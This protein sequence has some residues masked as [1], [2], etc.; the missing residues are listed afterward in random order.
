[1]ALQMDFDYK[2]NTCNYWKIMAADTAYEAE[3]TN[4]YFGLFKDADTRF[5]SDGLLNQIMQHKEIIPLVDL[6]RTQM[7]DYVKA[8]GEF[9]ADA[10]D[11]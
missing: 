4:V 7:Y 5:D 10:I 9:F 2:G 11:V 6:T 8:S 3:S 1:M